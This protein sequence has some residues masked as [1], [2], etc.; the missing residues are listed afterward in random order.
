[1]CGIFGA[2]A[3]DGTRPS[4]DALN[5]M[6]QS[7]LHRGPDHIGLFSERLCGMG[8]CRLSIIDLTERGN[9][10][11]VSDDG[12]IAVVQNGEIY[13]YIELREELQ[14]AGHRFDTSGDTEVLLRA[15]EAWGPDFVHRLNGMFAIAV[16]DRREDALYLFRDRLGV[17]PLYLYEAAPGHLLFASEIKALLQAGA[18]V[19]ADMTAAAQYLALNYV[20]Q[21]RTMFAGIRHL[22]PGHMARMDAQ[23][24]LRI[25]RYWDLA[26]T[27]G[28]TDMTEA[29]AQAGI[30]ALLDDATRIRMRADAPFGAFLSGGLDSSSVVGFMSLYKT[31]NLRSFSIGFDDARFDESS[32]AREAAERF[33]T[34]HQSQKMPVETTTRWARFV[35]H[36]DQPHGDVSFIPTDQVAG[37]AARDVRMVL[38]GD[39]ADEL[40]AGYEKYLDLFPGGRSDH[41]KE[42]WQDGFVRASGL[43]RD[44]EAERLLTGDL[45]DAFLDT[46][47]Y[48]PLSDE[49]RRAAQQDPINQVLMGETL[50]LLPGNN[51]VKPDRMAMA[52][53]LEVRSPFLDYRMAEFAFAIPGAMKLAGGETKA[54]M[55]RALLPMLGQS[56]TYRKKQMFTVPVGEWFR[57]ALAQFCRETLLDG[58]LEARDIVDTAIVALMIDAHIAGT[59]NNT[60]QLRALI[61]LELWF[62]LFIDRDPATL[63]QATQPGKAAA[64]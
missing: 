30:I 3:A 54:I 10:P 27:P 24:G 48:A 45:R 61:S 20:P 29:E 34:I 52:N 19:K 12:Q 49:I 13:N 33:G 11:Q 58:R 62:R 60:R 25:T 18:P 15:F 6:G 57:D 28:E 40:F 17:K 56:L 50:T 7:I 64:A 31:E 35:W 41:L 16:F 32:F 44:S 53:S 47:P 46:D 9:Q 37:M 14:K 4:D 59:Q 55:K 63:A 26:Q 2:F 42:G 5:A 21:P 43:M 22:S 38:T 39:G 23:S 36:C 8:N 51:L 1:M